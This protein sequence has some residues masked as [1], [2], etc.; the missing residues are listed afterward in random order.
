MSLLDIRTLH[1]FAAIVF[2]VGPLGLLL[3]TRGIRTQ[4]IYL[5][6]FANLAAGI[7]LVL[8]G[9]RGFIPEVA[10]FHGSQILA[11][12]GLC[13]RVQTFESLLGQPL[14]P[15]LPRYIVV[16]TIY[17][18]AYVWAVETQW[19][20]LWRMT[21]VLASHIGMYLWHLWVY[22]KFQRRMPSQGIRL[23]EIAT[24][25]ILFAVVLRLVAIHLL[26][27]DAHVFA[28]TTLYEISALALV[29][30][31]VLS[32]VGFLRVILEDMEAKR[33]AS[34]EARLKSEE[35][36]SRLAVRGPATTIEA[37]SSA[38]AHE[39]NQPLTALQ[40]NLQLLQAS[41]QGRTDPLTSAN[42]TWLPILEESLNETKRAA[43]IVSNLQSVL[44]LGESDYRAVR[45]H[46]AACLARD[47]VS[48][49]DLASSRGVVL[50]VDTDDATRHRILGNED[51]L[52]QVFVNLFINACE[53]H[54]RAGPDAFEAR[55][56]S[57]RFQD[58]GSV[59]VVHV[60]DNG[61][62][63]GSL[64]TKQLFQLFQSSKP[65]HDTG[66]NPVEGRVGV[67]VG[68][69]LAKSIVERHGGRI[70][71]RRSDSE[72]IFI[73]SFPLLPKGT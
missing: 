71:Y 48:R 37:F 5:W 7:S 54:A 24:G 47:L 20:D 1:L 38:I 44:V 62:G 49:S 65:G 15:L 39:I 36:A 6:V 9:M 59:L 64:D 32:N 42:T 72:S 51:Q 17:L 4:P 22:A 41:A 2:L 67:G 31:G 57:V 53:A 61:P 33:S 45:P 50:E 43:R 55:R 11:V 34:E 58:D 52:T 25:V 29:C 8:I 60:T 30:F 28:Q 23:I 14:R 19:T 3:T 21:L 40:T 63:L 27:E 18:A 68:L 56:A 26:N 10:S 16:I 66:R 46:T 13:L 73:L 70:D 12:L 35:E 69:W